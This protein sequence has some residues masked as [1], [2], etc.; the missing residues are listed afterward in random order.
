MDDDVDFISSNT[1]S[2]SD[3]LIFTD[4]SGCLTSSAAKNTCNGPDPLVM[5]IIPRN[6]QALPKVADELVSGKINKIFSS[7]Q[8][9]A[10]IAYL[11]TITS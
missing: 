4:F 3:Q 1:D 9:N 2:T 10:H 11:F 7:F 5:V 6:S 8:A